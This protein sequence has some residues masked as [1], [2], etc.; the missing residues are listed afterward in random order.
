MRL[1][2]IGIYIFAAIALLTGANDLIQ[3][4]A[5]LKAF[6]STLPEQAFGDP[7]AD[8]LFRFF[9]GLWFGVGVLFLLFIR[10]MNRYS[11]AMIALLSVVALGGLGRVLSIFQYGMPEAPLG[12]ALVCAGLLSELIIAPIMLWWLVFRAPYRTL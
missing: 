5:S 12:F 3:G 1:F 4:F 10:D 6:G 7:M 9:A 11:P 2:T 8:N